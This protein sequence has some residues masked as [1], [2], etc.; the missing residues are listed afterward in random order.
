MAGSDAVERAQELAAF[1]LAPLVLGGRMHL[2]RPFGPQLSLLVGGR[3]EVVDTDLRSRIDVARVRRARLLAP[4]DILPELSSAEWTLLCGLNDLLQVTNHALAGP[5]TRS[6]HE[7]LLRGVRELCAVIADPH[8]VGAALARHATFA[9]VLELVRTDTT[10][11]WWTGTAR[12]RGQPPPGR[13]LRWRQLRRVEVQTERVTLHEM[14]TGLDAVP[15]SEF[16]EVLG[17]WL[18]RSPL[19]DIAGAARRRPVFAWSRSTLAL[20]L[21]PPGRAIAWRAL[22][23]QP[24]DLVAAVLTQAARDIPAGFARPKA[25]AEEFAAEV[26]AGFSA[27]KGGSG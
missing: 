12:Y 19:T 9:R 11:S 7:R 14:C 22:S 2:V 21:T 3:N 20:I 4:V 13:L 17:L 23:R 18:T 5:L 8:D 10:V 24:A 27:R 1:V 6:R 15:Q 16:D 26:A 25:L